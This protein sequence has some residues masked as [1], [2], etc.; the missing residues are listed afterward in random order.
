MMDGYGYGYGSMMGWVWLFWV[1]LVIGL[2]LL[3]ILTVRSFSGG[4]RDGR[5]ARRILDER[6]ARGEMTT[7]EYRERLKTLRGET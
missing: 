5:S 3:G 2:V 7:E 1:L 6:Y 4:A